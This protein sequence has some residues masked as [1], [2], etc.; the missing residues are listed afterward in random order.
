MQR[1]RNSSLLRTVVLLIPM[2]AGACNSQRIAPTDNLVISIV[3]TNDVH[4]ELLPKAGR[5][6][7]AGISGY[8][9]ALRQKRS[10]DGGAVLLIDAGDMW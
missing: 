5:G 2:F 9:N 7:L 6:G 1:S 10:E 3:G 4:G 8:V